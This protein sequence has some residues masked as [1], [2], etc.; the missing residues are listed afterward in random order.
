M[1]DYYLQEPLQSLASVLYHIVAESVGKYLA[2][3]RRNSNPRAFPLEDVP[4]VLKVG[5][6]AADNGMFQFEGG[7]VGATDDL[8]RSVHV[9]GSAMSLGVA[10]LFMV[11][12]GLALSSIHVV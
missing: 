9:A 3:Q 6:A 8:V 1:S 4:E 12:E 2:R 5:V 10:D 11:D 7:N